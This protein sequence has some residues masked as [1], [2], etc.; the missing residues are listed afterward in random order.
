MRDGFALDYLKGLEW[1]D[2]KAARLTVLDTQFALGQRFLAAWS[3]WKSQPEPKA[4]LDFIAIDANPLDRGDLAEIQALPPHPEWVPLARLLQLQWPVLTPNLHQLTFEQGRVRL[5]LAWGEPEFWLR[6]LMLAADVILVDPNVDAR[7]C[8]A[9]ARLA[10]P[11]AA[12]LYPA[13][14]PGAVPWLAAMRSAGFLAQASPMGFSSSVLAQYQPTF[15][16]RIQPGR[17]Q[18]HRS[19][20]G[21]TSRQALIVGAGLAGCATAWALRRHGWHCTVIDQRDG[22]AQ[23]TSGNAAGLFHGVVHGE[24]GHHARFSRAAALYGV[25]WIREALSHPLAH[26][27]DQPSGEISGLL[28]LHD[29]NVD[30]MRS[31]VARLGLPQSYVQ[32]LDAAQA[33][34]LAGLTINRPAWFYPQ[35]GWVRPQQL[36]AYWLEAAQAAFLGGSRVVSITQEAGLWHVLGEQ[37][38]SL[39]H[40]PVL[41]LANAQ[42]ALKLLKPWVGDTDWTVEMV[43]GQISLLPLDQIESCRLT[44]PHLPLAGAG[45]LVPR[46][47]H[48]MVFGAT[49]QRADPDPCVRQSDHDAN[50]SQLEELWGQPLPEAIW[51]STHWQGRT[52]WRCVTG[53]R[54][55]IVGPVPD[56]RAADG[57]LSQPRL[58]PRLAGL[59]VF[60]ALGSRGLTWAPLAAEIV[61]CGVSGAAMPLESSLL[62][63]IDPARFVVRARR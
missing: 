53:D 52:A 62:D 13:E 9:L 28:R 14:S 7:V 17:R 54:L 32:A 59:H 35:G 33:S 19:R 21:H 50:L 11:G 29:E 55:P 6:E 43:R 22:P 27:S 26:R 61:A 8:K 18:A 63:A 30:T 15:T 34:K 38:Q 42:N 58:V 25:A 47:P 31:T 12:L 45:Y 57:N 5:L 4:S 24:D 20:W 51:N 60:M 49:S 1:P 2:A 37:G 3:S 56:A 41:I 44:I 46:T 23:E 36:C 48:G 10:A 39:A 40:A 16:P